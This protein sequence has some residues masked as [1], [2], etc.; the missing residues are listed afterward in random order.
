MVNET[1]LISYLLKVESIHGG[2]HHESGS[3]L[4]GRTRGALQPVLAEPDDFKLLST[5][6]D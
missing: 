3:C 6:L 2:G 4:V 5:V 1:G